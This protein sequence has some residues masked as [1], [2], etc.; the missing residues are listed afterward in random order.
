MKKILILLMMGCFVFV[1]AQ[2]DTLLY[3]NFDI[4]LFS[5]V[6]SSL[7]YSATNSVNVTNSGW[8]IYSDNYAP[9]SSSL[10][11]GNEGFSYY[12]ELLWRNWHISPYI[13]SRDTVLQGDSTV[14]NDS[15]SNGLRSFSW[16]TP[17]DS[18]L[19]ILLSPNVWIGG[20][21][22]RFRWKSMPV[23]GPRHQDGYQVYVL[24]GG[25]YQ[26]LSI[27]FA[28]LE[29]DFVMKRMS[30]FNGSPDTTIK[31]L[32]YLEHNFGYYPSNEGVMHTQYTLPKA[33][34][35]GHVDSTRQHPF[36]QEFELDLSHIKEEFIQVL[37]VHNSY[38][39]V[40]I[41]LD[42][43]LILGSGSVGQFEINNNSVKL[44]PNPSTNFVKIELGNDQPLQ[45]NIISVNGNKIKHI[46]LNGTSNI[47]VTSLQPGYYLVEIIGEY[48]R[49]SGSFIKKI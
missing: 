4:E 5:V 21:S 25:G 8:E 3:N 28:N 44:F 19:N 46:V 47:D 36:M 39:N 12:D 30:I 29:P 37:F 35:L 17:A 41:V 2:D 32:S 13:V 14:Y 23:Q 16:V 10:T 22:S 38:D 1:N 11:N 34:S 26:I 31:S 24:R 27:P 33:D 6:D 42:D 43:I 20:D 18:V 9:I 49:Y 48:G 40:G 15:I 45:A 7:D